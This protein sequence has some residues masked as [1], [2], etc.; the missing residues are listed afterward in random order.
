MTYDLSKYKFQP[1]DRV[2]IPDGGTMQHWV[3]NILVGEWAGGEGRTGTITRVWKS[4][5]G[6]S[7]PWIDIAPDEGFGVF[8]FPVKQVRHA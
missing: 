1:G 3:D 5:R 8:T 4:G 2:T 7:P 6:N